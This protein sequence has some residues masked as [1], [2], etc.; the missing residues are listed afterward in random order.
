MQRIMQLTILVFIFFFYSCKKEQYIQQIN[1]PLD[2]D[3]TFY[4]FEKDIRPIFNSNCN[5]SDCHASGGEGSYDFTR[6][7]VVASRVR[8]GTIDYRL[9]LP[10]DHPLHMPEDMKL[11][12]CDYFKIKTWIKQGFVEN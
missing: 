7:E 9:D 2:C 4:T 8:A 3:S 10:F 5:F 12:S 11:S 1:K 6:Y